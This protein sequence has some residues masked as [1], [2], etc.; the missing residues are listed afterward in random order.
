MED[1]KI[2]ISFFFLIFLLSNLRD[3]MLF[4]NLNAKI[5]REKLNLLLF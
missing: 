4:A 1:V 2:I 3:E 5:K